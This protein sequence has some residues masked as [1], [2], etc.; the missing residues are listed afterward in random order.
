MEPG[1]TSIEKQSGTEKFSNGIEKL[2]N[3]TPALEKVMREP[4]EFKGQVQP[5]ADAGGKIKPKQQPNNI[6]QR[7]SS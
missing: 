3:V 1:S 2:E 5:V 4:A 6:K 7:E